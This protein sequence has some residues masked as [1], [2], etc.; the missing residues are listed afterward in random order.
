MN[1]QAQKV[2]VVLSGGGPRGVTHV[3]VLKALEDNNIPIDYITGTSMGAIVGGLY[4]SGYSP[5]EIEQMLQSEELI[6]WLSTAIDPNYKYYFKQ[7]RPN[8]SWQLFKI[9]Y[10]REVK[11]KL[12]SNIISPYKLDL[13]FLELF[14]GASAASKYNFDELYIPFRCVASDIEANKPVIIGQGQLEKAIRASMSFPFYFKPVEID[15]RLMFDGGMYNN[16]PVDVLTESF[17]PDV[18]IG[19]KAASNYGPPE[20]DDIISQI[21]S[22]L[23]ANTEY[24]INP[25][26]GVLITPQL[27]SVNPTDFSNTQDF[28]DSG[29]VATI[30]QMEYLKTH[31]TREESKENKDIKRNKFK[32]S[33]PVLK[34]NNVIISGV[35]ET[36]KVY[37]NRLIKKELFLE[38][39]NQGDLSS[40]GIY[41]EIK[42]L[43]YA[44]LSDEKVES[45]YPELIH[46]NSGYNVIFKVTPSHMLEAEIGGLISSQAI[47]EIFL[48]LQYNTWGRTALGLTGNT[49]LGRFHN[50]VHFK[51]R[52]DIPAKMPL[53]IALGYTLNGWNYF[54]TKTYFFSDDNPGFLIQRENYWDLDLAT[55]ISRSSRMRAQFQIGNNR[56]EYYQDNQFTR[57]DTA[58]QTNFDYYTPALIY[59]LNTM[60]RKQFPSEGVMFRISG[61]YINGE[62]ENIP[63]STSVD[64]TRYTNWHSWFQ[65]R[66]LYDNYYNI[67][68]VFDFGFYGQLVLS[69]EQYFNNYVS[70]VLAAPAFEPL[71][72]N[73]TLFLPQ[74]RAFS[75]AGLGIKSIFH[76]FRNIDFRGEAY[77]F[78]PYKEILKTE[79]NKAALGDPFSKQYYIFSARAVYHAPFGPISMGLNYFESLEEPFVFSIHLGFY[80]F[81]KRPLNW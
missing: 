42:K 37:L 3:G 5:D 33:V 70:T 75:Y 52:Y 26:S 11:A 43:Y 74:F 6:N 28:I 60:N 50:S 78:Q 41:N 80:I 77:V 17:N 31:I 7:P 69:D 30:R 25:D 29:Y 47:N 40:Q 55:P 58:D 54:K 79:D 45:V 72:E 73:Q 56:D 62:E 51:A 2:G 53:S 27:W 10:D 15:D 1:G 23:M 34:I 57:L 46:D 4:A 66:L 12:P 9:T 21:Q 24:S 35:S 61:R 18:I 67:S 71:P 8:A 64:T 81:N 38:L 65:V 63:G 49:Y 13:G 19:C 16:F 59:E 14:S 76:P 48:Q 20:A 22:M 39:V 44:I 36:R 68:R 32:S